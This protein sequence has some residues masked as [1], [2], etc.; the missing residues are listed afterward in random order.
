MDESDKKYVAAGTISVLY[1][2]VLCLFW[3]WVLSARARGWPLSVTSA[4][5][6]LTCFVFASVPVML[7]VTGVGLY[8]LQARTRQKVRA[9]AVVT[10]IFLV[11]NAV[12]ALYWA[13]EA[14]G[15]LAPVANIVLMV[16]VA[17][18]SGIVAFILAVAAASLSSDAV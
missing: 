7:I 10:T 14:K 18:P 6:G 5:E 17:I 12:L 9:A 4:V 15:C 13:S 11:I 3:V 1:G 2:V 16:F 8:R